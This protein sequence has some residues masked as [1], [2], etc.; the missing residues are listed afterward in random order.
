[1]KKEK[2]GLIKMEK[3]TFN[4][5]SKKINLNVKKLSGLKN[6]TGGLMFISGK[7]AKPLL[8]EFKKPEKIAFTGLFVFFPFMILWLYRKNNVLDAK[9]IRPFEWHIPTRKPYF[10]VLEIPFNKK[11]NKTAQLFDGRI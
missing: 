4:Y 1:M 5:K 2:I 11:Y 7:K 3:F 10:K 8:F 6:F 9:K